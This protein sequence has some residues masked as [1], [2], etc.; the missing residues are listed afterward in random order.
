MSMCDA[1]PYKKISLIR[2]H[3]CSHLGYFL[4]KPMHNYEKHSDYSASLEQ[5]TIHAL[6]ACVIINVMEGIRVL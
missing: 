1:A 4:T 3:G 2:A 6:T 5:P